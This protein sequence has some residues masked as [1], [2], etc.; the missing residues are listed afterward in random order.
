[1]RSHPL[2]LIT[3]AALVF[4]A[5]ACSNDPGGGDT[6]ASGDGIAVT[7]KDFAI[8]PAVTTAPTGK[9]SFDITNDGPSVHEFEV[10][11]TDAEPDA[12]PVD[13]GVAQTQ[14]SEIVDEVENIA[15]GTSA[16][17]SVDLDP[18]S[19]VIICNI[20]GHYGA[21]MHVGFTVT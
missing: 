3:A 7:L 5:A 12:L 15:P 13:S 17:L 9:V 8:A 2:V 21:G 19:Y 6:G 20:A 4:G 16:E 14:E 10:L 11:A 1:V 18:G